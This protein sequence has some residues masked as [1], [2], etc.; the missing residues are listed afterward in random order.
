MSKEVLA[1]IEKSGQAFEEFKV[2]NDK[3]LEDIKAGNDSRATELEAKIVKIEKDLKEATE[4]KRKLEIE[5]KVDRERIEELEA[6]AKVPGKTIEVKR[7][8]EYADKFEKFI[9]TGGQDME[10]GVQLKALE[11][12][13]HEQKD[14]TIGSA[15]GGGYAVPEQIS[16]DVEVQE[17]LF[18][19][20]RED[21]KVVQIGTSDYK[22]LV[23][24]RGTTG[25]WVGETGTRTAT[26]TSTLREVVPTQGE[27]YAYPQAS[28][29]S[30]DDIFFNVA[31]WLSAE[32]AETFAVEEATAV[33]TGNGTTK[34]TGML[35]TTPT[36]VDDFGSPLR[37]AAIYQ[38]VASA[39]SPDAILPDAL[40]DLVYKLNSRYRAGAKFFFNSTTAASIRKLKDTTNQYL[41]QPGLQ[42]GEP[43][44]L[45]GY[46]TSIWEQMA[47]VASNAFPV[48][49]GNL[50]RGYV[51]V[52]RVGLRI[53]RD[54]VTTPGYVK[55]YVR[56]REGGIVL[57][58]NAIKFLRTT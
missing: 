47:S 29:W 16:R 52:D 3:R 19:P 27:L 38:Y 24:L 36:T 55:F 17:K 48:G 56:R 57:N 35:N 20:V 54:E 31:N 12:E 21:V 58:N 30:L 32:I 8:E 42:M 49:F 28:E 50:K 39:A 41:W 6:R 7:R 10:L 45:L 13:M 4:T 23:N 43:D 53:T 33:L 34:P 9:R 25:G 5:Q 44:R 46:P 37:S 18:S 1:A 51:L 40:I 2:V 26:A 14:V 11:R 15:A 22:E